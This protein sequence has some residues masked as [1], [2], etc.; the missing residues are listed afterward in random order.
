MIRVIE[1]L[2][3]EMQQMFRCHTQARTISI[4]SQDNQALG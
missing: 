4:E 2:R 3:S 1:N